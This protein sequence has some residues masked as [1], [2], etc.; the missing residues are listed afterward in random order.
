LIEDCSFFTFFDSDSISYFQLVN[1]VQNHFDTDGDLRLLDDKEVPLIRRAVLPIT[2]P[3]HIKLESIRE[4]RLKVN[5][6]IDGSRETRLFPLN[7]RV[8]DLSEGF[9]GEWEFTID[10]RPIFTDQNALLS[11]Y[12]L[13]NERIVCHR[14]NQVLEELPDPFVLQ[15]EQS[16][17]SDQIVTFQLILTTGDRIDNFC[18]LDYTVE[19]VKQLALDLLEL[20]CELKI[21]DDKETV[22]DPTTRI[23]D[24]PEPRILI[25]QECEPIRLGSLENLPPDLAQ[26][27][28]SPLNRSISAGKSS[29]LPVTVPV[30]VDDS[31]EKPKVDKDCPIYHF[32][33]EEDE[34]ELPIPAD[35]TV[36]QTK[37]KVAIRYETNADYVSLLF[38]GRNMKDE[39]L[40]IHQRIGNKKII[41]YIRR[42]DPIL[43][44]SIGYGARRGVEKPR[45]FIERV[46][47][48]ERETSQDHR[49]CS[50]CLIFYDYD[51]DAARDA[52]QMLESH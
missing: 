31:I 39:T 18:S 19:N 44:E 50:R 20:D 22:L 29:P 13:M 15:N 40:L 17:E 27:L 4:S 33:Y 36:F 43:L 49:T 2:I 7:A 11:N 47:R 14:R 41:V 26:F 25:V 23:K 35:W 1:F 10:R 8:S 6:E 30:P 38:C 45:D 51:V 42:F 34:F 28:S 9:T 3:C 32:Q 52:L 37:E 5:L 16:D 24:L 12:P 46:N 21:C 48:L